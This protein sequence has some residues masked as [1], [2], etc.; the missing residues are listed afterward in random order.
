MILTYPYQY[1]NIRLIVV[2]IKVIKAETYQLFKI[3]CIRR[4]Q[5][6]NCDV[7]V[8]IPAE[9][10]KNGRWKGCHSRDM[11]NIAGGKRGGLFIELEPNI[12]YYW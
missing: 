4:D 1:V 11:S 9:P 12:D 6:R 7:S 3:C 2:V 8:K 10:D 5:T